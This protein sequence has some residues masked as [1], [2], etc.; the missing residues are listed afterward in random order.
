VGQ[1][2]RRWVSL[3]KQRVASAPPG[4]A[5]AVFGGGDTYPLMLAGQLRRAGLPAP[6][7]EYPFAKHLG[8]RYKADLAYP[9]LGLLVEVDGMVHRVKARFV[10]D[11]ERDQIIFQLGLRKLRV[12]PAQVRDGR[13]LELVRAALSVEL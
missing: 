10:A 5:S 3:P 2:G 8:R 1:W 13:A 9:S 12:S 6:L 4:K 11:L 7:L